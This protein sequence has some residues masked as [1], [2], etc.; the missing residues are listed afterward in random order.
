[1]TLS[2]GWACA[3]NDSI[4]HMADWGRPADMTEDLQGPGSGE[5]YSIDELS[6][7]LGRLTYPPLFRPPN[8]KKGGGR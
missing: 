2:E 6:R 7:F 3:Y 8:K 1:M 5:E 4:T